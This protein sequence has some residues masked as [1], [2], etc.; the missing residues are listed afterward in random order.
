MSY[1]GIIGPFASFVFTGLRVAADQVVENAAGT[2]AM[3]WTW[4]INEQVIDLAHKGF[5]ALLV[6]WI[7]DRA[8][9]GVEWFN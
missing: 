8:V 2:S 9:R 1:Y 5:Y 6:G 3:P 4:P 7:T